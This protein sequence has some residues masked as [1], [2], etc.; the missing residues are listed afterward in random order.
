VCL[1][2]ELDL[3]WGTEFTYTNYNVLRC[4]KDPVNTRAGKRGVET[5]RGRESS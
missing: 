2:S 1:V 5:K 3:Q 4:T